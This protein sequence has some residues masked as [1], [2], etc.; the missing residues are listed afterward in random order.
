MRFNLSPFWVT[1][2]DTEAFLR[3]RMGFTTEDGDGVWRPNCDGFP[4]CF[5]ESRR[6]AVEDLRLLQ[7]PLADATGDSPGSRMGKVLYC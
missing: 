2:L 3:R 7:S 5:E 4:P 1:G 6:D